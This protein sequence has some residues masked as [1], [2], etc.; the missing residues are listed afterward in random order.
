MKIM[1]KNSRIEEDP[2]VSYPVLIVRMYINNNKVNP[3]ALSEIETVDDLFMFC[4]NKYNICEKDIG[5]GSIFKKVS[6]Y[7]LCSSVVCR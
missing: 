2:S 1:I 3:W 4:K 5:S 6:K 7:Q